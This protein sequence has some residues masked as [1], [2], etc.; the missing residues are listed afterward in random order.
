M[1]DRSHCSV[2]HASLTLA[3]ACLLIVPAAAS[4]AAPA[5]GPAE[6]GA[7]SVSFKSHVA[8][9]LLQRCQGCHGAEKVKGEYRLDSFDRLMKAGASEDAPIVAGKPDK[10]ELYRLITSADEDERMPKKG[11][12]LTKEQVALIGRWIGQGAKFDGPDGAA[13]LSA[14]ASVRYPAPPEAYPR[15]VP[16]AAL[17]FSPDGKTLA[18]GGYHEITLWDPADGR[19]IGRINGVAQRTQSLAWSADGSLLAA[20]SG[21]PGQVGEVRLFETAD[22]SKGTLLDRISDVMCVVRFS[23][24]GDRLAAGGADNAI[25]IYDTGAGGK[26]LRTIEQHA[27]W[28]TDLAFSPDGKR[29]ASASRDKSARVFDAGTGA[30]EAAYLGQEEPVYAIAWGKE[31]EGK[32]VYT[33]GHDRRIDAWRPA[34]A[35]SED[36]K[37]VAK[38]T[39]FGGDVTRLVTS[40]GFLFAASSDGQARQYTVDKRQLVRSYGPMKDAA[41][42]LAIDEKNRRLAVGSYDGEV[43]VW[44]FEDGKAVTAFVAAPGYGGR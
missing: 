38:I 4:H 7:T 32:L 19:L 9:I 28:V 8:P 11:D 42:A 1:A 30:M 20:A 25:R 43:R 12:P 18:A 6:R 31:D 33:A 15:P 36:A 27:D 41:Y 21:T 3:L 29:L 40:S 13:P 34:D 26:R 5:T 44:N 2:P 39:G 17:A 22:P 10:S 23:P 37:A 14:Y 16:V 35:K 24:A